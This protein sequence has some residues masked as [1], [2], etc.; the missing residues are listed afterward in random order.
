MRRGFDA[1]LVFSK[2][3]ALVAIATGS[4]ACAEHEQGSKPLQ[5][6]LCANYDDED[7]LLSDLAKGHAVTFE[8]LLE[9]KRITKLPEQLRYLE[10]PVEVG[11]E[12]EAVLGLSRAPL[13]H[14][15]PELAYPYTQYGRNDVNVSGAWDR[16]SF[17]IRVRGKKYVRA[18]RQFY[19]AM[20][21]KQCL[22]AGT[23]L[24]DL[25]GCVIA[26]A[27]RLSDS[28]KTA[29]A[30]AQKKYESDLRLKAKDDSTAVS[31]EMNALGQRGS[32]FHFGFI[33][34]RWADEALG[35]VAYHLNPGSGVDA[36]HGGPYTKEQLLEWA[37][38]KF[39][40]PLRP[41]KSTAMK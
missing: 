12:P 25:S 17:A 34:V 41:L 8:P 2:S 31:R 18:L 16:D 6:A 29:M 30:Q 40:T 28:A 23:F 35:T 33:S 9:R 20:Q 7:K 39:T 22:F 24:T 3:G 36:Y 21:A 14:Y 32:S 10:L 13:Q 27:E 5:R 37:R 15:L 1:Q 4:D 19:E 26:N 38:S 11:A